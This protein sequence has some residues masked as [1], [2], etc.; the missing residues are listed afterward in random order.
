MIMST[1]EPIHVLFLAG[2]LTGSDGIRAMLHDAGGILV[3]P[4]SPSDPSSG[5]DALNTQRSTVLLLGVDPT[6]DGT[7]RAL[8]TVSA[9][10]ALAPIVLLSETDDDVFALRV[11]QA[12]AQDFLVT[13]GLQAH[14]L[15]RAVRF[16][17]ER[18]RVREALR[19]S[20]AHKDAILDTALDCIIGMDHEGLVIEW[21][22]VAERTFGHRREDV[23]GRELAGI[24][25]PERLRESHRKGLAHFLATGEG[26]VID[27][28]V[29][30]PALRANGSEFPV[31]LT[32]TCVSV[33][34]TPLFTGY[35]RDISERR[36]TEDALRESETRYQRIAAN[37]PGMVYQFVLH[38]DG[39]V[40]FP[41]AS[42]GSRELY[43][44]EPA[45]ITAN[46][47]LLIGI[48]HPDDQEAFELSVAESA[49]TLEPWKWAGRFKHHRTGMYRW[50]EGASRP[51]QEPDGDILWDGLLVDITHRMEAEAELR[52]AKEKAE[53]ATVAKSQFLATM[54][55][56]IRTPMNAVIGMTGLL[57][58]TELSAE[59]HEYAQ[60]I[61]DSGDALLTIINDILDYSKIE[62]GQLE[63]EQQP[64][65][66]RDVLE[67]SL[68]FVAT[69]AAE[70][71]LELAYVLHPD[72]PEA[73][74]GDV[75]RLRQ[76]LVNLLS[77]AVKFTEQGEVVLTL[78]SVPLTADR[79]ELH[80]SVR[81]TGIGIPADR[82]DR[83]FRSF[84]QIDS[85]TTRRYGGTG[86]GLVICKRLCEIMGGHI[87][88]ESVAGEG[89]TFHAVL[90]MEIASPV[91]VA[92]EP[93]TLNLDG[94]RLL[95]VDDNPTNRQILT[96]Q[97]QS[98]GMI[99]KESAS[100]EEALTR[101]RQ[102]EQFD[103]AILD[104]Q[105]PDM[106]GIT[107][108]R[109]I[110]RQCGPDVMPL[111]GL[112]SVTR[113]VAEFEDAGFSRMLTKP[114]KQAQLYHVLAQV[115]ST[116]LP[117]SDSHPT[118]SPFDPTLG[119]RLPLRILMAEDL[120]V[121]QKLMQIL[122]GKFGYRADSAANGL[123]VLQALERQAYDL[124][125]MD[126][127]MPE[128]DGLEASRRIRR[129]LP[130]E[131][132]PRIV[133]LT[134]NAMREDE[135]ICLAA[136]M[137]DYMAKP[138][139]PVTLRSALIRSGEWARDRTGERSSHA[140][141]SSTAPASVPPPASP[142]AV[143]PP[144]SELTPE[145]PAS[146]ALSEPPVA[147][148]LPSAE[149]VLDPATLAELRSMRDILPE[150]I[151]VF[152]SEVRVKLDKML[153]A[154]NEADPVQLG[155]LAHAVR[156]AAGAMGGRGLAA[157]CYR[158]EQLGRSGTVEGA[159]ALLPEVEALFEQL[160]QALQAELE[161]SDE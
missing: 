29:E 26:P 108:A 148:D 117:E 146:V 124:I 157:A 122:L 113:R 21:N 128:M 16:A 127:Q 155:Q 73:V 14:R 142:A 138:I 121:N 137:D 154:V 59:Q 135:E 125:L 133:A 65:D 51:Q 63:L 24:I 69:R 12:G 111:V 56:E 85:S 143:P 150:L 88:V 132:Q 87:R 43:G 123:E 93:G 140:P 37:V 39:S 41:F 149:P 115:F 79:C 49:R 31:E 78:H 72:T 7:Q 103:I 66:L 126:V 83:L 57:L 136:G 114:I 100:G 118:A 36:Q 95:I 52:D 96:L 82:M 48:I 6:P 129:D 91:H 11:I 68:D 153:A 64:F 74:R 34:D 10:A 47:M 32:I 145:S 53:A 61:Q 50:V 90:P 158:L 45:D 19:R 94:R 38:P 67:A 9:Y 92:L 4:E 109:E 35:L 33:R 97:A 76:I 75:T 70:K 8:E 55:H 116:L 130:S 28:R 62:A 15:Q 77:N 119:Q 160:C 99:S 141:T 54:S 106:D 1:S 80:F 152:Q 120:A 104:I 161:L 42:E 112:S 25:V 18:G 86:L 27:K 23:L 147:A 89:S 107:L 58:D 84:S 2:G 44:I 13:S 131:R 134:A 110:H 22:L 17:A 105:M 81:D 156:G 139:N 144:A 102:G 40:A 60:I 98:W 159:L 46:P 71:G 151:E 5:L 20:E 3:L 30:L 101:L